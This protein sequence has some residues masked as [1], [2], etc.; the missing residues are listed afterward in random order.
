MPVVPCPGALR[1]IPCALVGS[2]PRASRLSDAAAAL[3]FGR[4][5]CRS[6]VTFSVP[7]PVSRPRTPTVVSLAMVDAKL[8]ARELEAWL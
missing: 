2:A 4:P 5:S 3:T 7:R 1:K 8:A 6:L